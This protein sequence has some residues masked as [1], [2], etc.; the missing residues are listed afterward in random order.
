MVGKTSDKKKTRVQEKKTWKIG[1]SRKK[2]AEEK[3][4]THT[5]I[6]IQSIVGVSW[7]KYN[8][9]SNFARIKIS[10]NTF[11]EHFYKF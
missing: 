11:F 1:E 8:R 5:S 3:E 7:C 10:A 6:S 4:E 2:K 9:L